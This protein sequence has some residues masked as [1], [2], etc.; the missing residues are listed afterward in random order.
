MPQ[1]A[2]VCEANLEVL[3]DQ[4]NELLQHTLDALKCVVAELHI[5]PEAVA[6]PAPRHEGPANLHHLC[7]VAYL[8]QAPSAI[9]YDG[10]ALQCEQ[11][12]VH[13]AAT[14]DICIQFGE[15]SIHNLVDLQDAQ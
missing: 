8:L 11:R 6:D 9:G 15:T 12:L 13:N 10:R 14:C 7:K 5:V 1:D 3:L 2:R 4:G